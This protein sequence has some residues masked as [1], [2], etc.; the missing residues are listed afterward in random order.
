MVDLGDFVGL[1]YSGLCD[2][3]VVDL[4]FDGGR[5]VVVGACGLIFINAM[6]F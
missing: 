1:V 2:V 4:W 6:W 3:E 5:A